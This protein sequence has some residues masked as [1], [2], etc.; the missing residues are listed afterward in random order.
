MGLPLFDR[1][2]LLFGNNLQ[3]RDRAALGLDRYGLRNSQLHRIVLFA[4]S[5]YR[6]INA[7]RS[8]NLVASFESLQ[9]R[10]AVLLCLALS[11]LL[12]SDYQEIKNS[13]DEDPDR[14]DADKPAAATC[15][16]EEKNA[17]S[18]SHDHQ[19]TRK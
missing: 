15:L 17:W 5:Y 13:E 2:R 8:D 1:L 9:K 11:P 18:C 6:P 7:S 12:R 3:S 19:V 4:D 14:Q 10:I 16:K